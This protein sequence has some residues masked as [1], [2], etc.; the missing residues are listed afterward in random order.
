MPKDR[1]RNSTRSR[2]K[3]NRLI[4]TKKADKDDTFSG[5]RDDHG[6]GAATPSTHVIKAR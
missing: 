5:K 3:H 6:F 2:L 1:H 4:P